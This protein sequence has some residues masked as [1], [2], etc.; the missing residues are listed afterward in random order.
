MDRTPS[1]W[2]VAIRKVD[3]NQLQGLRYLAT[4]LVADL[5]L[6]A[7]FTTSPFP[8]VSFANTVV[9][10][11]YVGLPVGAMFVSPVSS[12]TDSMPLAFLAM[13]VG[14]LVFLGRAIRR[15][16]PRFERT[17]HVAAVF[18]VLAGA[19]SLYPSL[20]TAALINRYLGDFYPL[21]AFAA[22]WGVA[23]AAPSIVA[24]PKGLKIGLVSLLGAGLCAEFW[25]NFALAYVSWWR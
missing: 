17:I 19:A 24:L 20:T 9:P 22:V 23:T 5:R 16:T 21:V 25:I 3:H 2:W 8:Y 12:I 4:S 13:V 15:S 1:P 10:I 6:N 18:C 11:R 14:I 7:I